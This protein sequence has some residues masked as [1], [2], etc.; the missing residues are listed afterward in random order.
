MKM[1]VGVLVAVVL[2]ACAGVQQWTE[3]WQ[4][5][6]RGEGPQPS[7]VF[8]FPEGRLVYEL[9]MRRPELVYPFIHQVDTGFYNGQYVH[10]SVPGLLAM[11]GEGSWVSL[12]NW[13]TRIPQ[14][15]GRYAKGGELGLVQND[16]GSFGPY[17]LM[18]RGGTDLERDMVPPSLV[19]GWLVEGAELLKT[20]RKGDKLMEVYGQNFPK[21]PEP[22]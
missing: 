11:V 13:R 1:L 19:L 2:A 20:L 22:Y 6:Q 4:P 15:Q 17:L 18:M 3:G 9:N 12:P 5:M 14:E 21:G 8:V 16:D 7:V 10:R